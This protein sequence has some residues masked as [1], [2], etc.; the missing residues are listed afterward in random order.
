MRYQHVSEYLAMC[1]RAFAHTAAGGRVRMGWAGRE[2]DAAEWRRE[3]LTAL[4]RRIT[5]VPANHRGK[6]CRKLDPLYQ[7]GQMRD[8]RRVN[9][10]ASR[11][12]VHPC[13]RLETAELQ[14]RFRWSYGP[15]GLDVRLFR[16]AA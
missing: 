9:E 16:N 5:V 2:M 10:Y 12:I 6:P 15:D 14:R 7:L 11:R 13:N 1:R 3:F 8:A 4:H